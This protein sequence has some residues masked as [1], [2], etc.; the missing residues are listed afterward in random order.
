MEKSL[1]K[2]HPELVPE[3]SAKNL[4][5]MPDDVSYGSNKIYWWKGPCGHEWQTSVKARHAGEKCPICA[6]ARVIPGVNDLATVR[7]DLAKQWSD[8]NDMTAAEVTIESHRKAWWHGPCGHEWQSEIRSRAKHGTGCPYCSSR[9]LLPGFND[10]KTRFPDVAAE[11]S[12]R[13]DPLQ[14]E[15]VTAFSNRRVWWKCST[16]GN[17]WYALISTRSGGSKCPYCTGITLLPGFNDLKTRYPELAAEWSVRNGDLLPGSLNEK[18][19]KNV[20][21]TCSICGHEYRAVIYSRVKGLSCPACANRAVRKGFNDLATTDP[22]LAKDWDYERNSMLPTMVSRLSHKRVWWRCRYGHHWS[23]KICERTVEGKGCIYCE[24]DFLASLPELTVLYYASGLKL[25]TIF[26][27]DGLIGIPISAYLP[28]VQLAIDF[29]FGNS[30]ERQ[31]EQSWKRHLCKARNVTLAEIGI[32][33]GFD[34]I[35]LLSTIKKAFTK[36]YLF[37]RSDEEE[38]L[39]RIRMAFDRIRKQKV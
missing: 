31:T 11:W 7:S 23:M 29:V 21:W 35:R 15:M 19:R 6:N 12:E 24:Q 30:K 17:E 16:C 20:W 34:K 36:A 28:E 26:G 37:I 18:S 8:R 9:K 5:V 13:N 22:V 1:A 3:W 25:K 27:D 14:P 10:L 32:S 2:M 39:E 38:D 33:T 4:P